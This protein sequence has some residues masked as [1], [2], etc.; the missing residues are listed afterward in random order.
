MD[1]T[2]WEKSCILNRQEQEKHNSGEKKET[3]MFQ[4]APAIV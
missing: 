2:P 1:T 4:Q 3:D